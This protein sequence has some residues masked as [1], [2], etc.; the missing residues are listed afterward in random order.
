MGLIIITS[1]VFAIY[2][3]YF[4]SDGHG[5]F[6]KIC[7]GILSALAN[8]GAFIERK[9]KRLFGRVKNAK[10][11]KDKRM[12]RYVAVNLENGSTIEFRLFRGTLCYK[13]F[14]ATLQ[15]VDEICYWAINLTD[16]EMEEL[17]W[18]EFVSKILPKKVELIEYLKSKRLY[19]NEAVT[20]S[21]E[22]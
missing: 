22:M 15:L 8:V 3:V 16:K 17:S 5:T 4:F 10:K 6:G 11:A 7:L 1:A 14:I 18:S 12:G 9:I 2:I 20:E 21:E 13:T 19:V